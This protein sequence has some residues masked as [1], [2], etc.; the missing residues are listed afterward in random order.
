MK[1]C[2][3]PYSY[4]LMVLSMPFNELPY[5]NSNA[6][7]ATP[8]SIATSTKVVFGHHHNHVQP[9]HHI[10]SNQPNSQTTTTRHPIQ[11][12]LIS[13]QPVIF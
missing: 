13:S 12:P 3:L 5:S 2:D 11:T 10:A 7:A 6:A 9:G 4:L 8:V 1:G